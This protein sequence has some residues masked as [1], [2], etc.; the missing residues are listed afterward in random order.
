M[1][2][3]GLECFASSRLGAAQEPRV[4]ADVP[5]VVPVEQPAQE[6][7]DPEAVASVLAS[8]ELPLVRVPVV[9]GSFQPLAL[10]GRHQLLVVVHTHRAADDLADVGQEDVDGLGERG[11]VL[12]ALHVERL[13]VR[14]EPRDWKE[15]C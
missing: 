7:L 9:V 4:E 12:A 13:D 10:V 5:D 14:R 6:P 3:S 1:L 8:P 2:T 11:V 15:E